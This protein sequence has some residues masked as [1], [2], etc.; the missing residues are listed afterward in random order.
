MAGDDVAERLDGVVAEQDGYFTAAHALD[1]GYLPSEIEAHVADGSWTRVE[2]DLLRL[3]DW[4]NH[5]LEE[6]SKWCVWLGATAVISHQSAAELHG[7]GS[8]HPQFVHVRV[9]G[10]ARAH[11]QRLAIHRGRLTGADIELSGAFRMTTPVRTVLDLAAGGISQFT[12][13]EVVADGLVLGRLVV[14]DLFEQAVECGDRV[15][16]RVETALR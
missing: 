10:T 4:P 5:D 2:T 7:M 6:Y 13:D 11:D 8:L 1:A 15:A 9:S 16:E 3:S 12:L 14:D